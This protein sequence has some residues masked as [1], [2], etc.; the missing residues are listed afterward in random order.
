M[1]MRMWMRIRLGSKYM[2]TN[3][4]YKDDDIAGYE[5]ELESVGFV[6]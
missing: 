3:D 1:T 2:G 4:V 5:S 6:Q